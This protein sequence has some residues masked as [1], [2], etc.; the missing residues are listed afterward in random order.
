MKR[1]KIS[2]TFALQ[3]HLQLDGICFFIPSCIDMF[4]LHWYLAVISSN[5]CLCTAVKKANAV[6]KGKWWFNSKCFF[7]KVV[8][9]NIVQSNW[10]NFVF[11]LPLILLDDTCK[12]PARIQDGIKDNSPKLLGLGYCAWLARFF[13]WK[14]RGLLQ[15]SVYF[16]IHVWQGLAS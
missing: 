12:Q 4:Q 15:H 3:H 8:N 11:F 5:E 6:M 2:L 7:G 1:G 13:H 16:Y 9:V 14:K 10:S